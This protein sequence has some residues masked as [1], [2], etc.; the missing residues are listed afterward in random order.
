M[1]TEFE[2]IKSETL[3]TVTGGTIQ[4]GPFKPLCRWCPP[5]EFPSPTFPS[6]TF[7]KPTWP[8]PMI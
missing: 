2:S 1:T 8:G 6:P 7:P 5:D 4:R 3:D